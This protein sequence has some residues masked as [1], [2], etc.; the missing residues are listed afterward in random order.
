MIEKRDAMT[1]EEGIDY[2]ECIKLCIKLLAVLLVES[3]K[4]DEDLR[5]LAITVS[6]I[7]YEEM[8]ELQK[9][10]EGKDEG[11]PF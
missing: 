7:L 4:E 5:G 10:R 11:F 9:S 2:K 1:K 6:A 3:K 8:A